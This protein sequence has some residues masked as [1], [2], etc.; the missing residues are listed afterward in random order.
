MKKPKDK[1]KK[2]YRPLGDAVKVIKD[3]LVSES[4]LIGKIIELKHKS[5]QSANL[6]LL[7]RSEPEKRAIIDS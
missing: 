3:P 1:L 4:N 6:G 5:Y 7:H 2:Y